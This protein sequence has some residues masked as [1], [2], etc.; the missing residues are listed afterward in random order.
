MSCACGH[1]ID[2]LKAKPKFTSLSPSKVAEAVAQARLK[3]G[4]GKIEKPKRKKSGTRLA[5]IAKRANA[6]KDTQE[7]LGYIA[8]ELTRVKGEFTM[9]DLDRL[10]ELMGKESSNDML[11]AMRENGIVFESGKGR[12]RSV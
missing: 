4:E 10:S 12:Y 3:A 6:I 5:R 9:E 7:R 2:L 11:V 1:T 8:S